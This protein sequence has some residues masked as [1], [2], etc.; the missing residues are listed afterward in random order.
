MVCYLYKSLTVKWDGYLCPLRSFLSRINLGDIPS[1]EI[2]G[3]QIV[4]FKT[5]PKAMQFQDV[6]ISD[7]KNLKVVMNIKI[8]SITDLMEIGAFY[9]SLWD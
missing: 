1:V 8:T 5:L 2:V 9:D 6:E 7:K 4:L 3:D